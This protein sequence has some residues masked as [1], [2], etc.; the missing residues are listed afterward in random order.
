M[1]L[2]HDLSPALDRVIPST[3]KAAAPATYNDTLRR[4]AAGVEMPRQVHCGLRVSL[5]AVQ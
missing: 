4:L 5:P 2:S 3:L 1:L